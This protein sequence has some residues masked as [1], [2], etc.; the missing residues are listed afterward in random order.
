MN[1]KKDEDIKIKKAKLKAFQG[2][3]PVVQLTL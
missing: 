1:V 2:L 3:P